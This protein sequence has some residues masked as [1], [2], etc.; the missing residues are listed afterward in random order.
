MGKP[1]AEL[2]AKMS[3]EEKERVAKQQEAL[4]EKG[5]KEKGEELE[6]AIVQNEVGVTINNSISH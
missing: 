4:G 5:L 2:A 6:K 3:A 1:S